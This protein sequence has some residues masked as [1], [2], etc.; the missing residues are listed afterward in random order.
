MTVWQSLLDRVELS[1]DKLV[2]GIYMKQWPTA[3]LLEMEGV[4]LDE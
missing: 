2:I 1:P 3:N 4:K